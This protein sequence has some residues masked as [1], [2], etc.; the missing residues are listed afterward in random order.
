MNGALVATGTIPNN[1]NDSNQLRIGTS[2]AASS[3][4]V[5]YISNVRFVKGT[6]VYTSAFTPST[7]PLTAITNTQL[8]T[9]QDAIRRDNSANAYAISQSGTVTQRSFSPFAPKSAYSPEVN[10]GSGYLDG[11]GDYLTVA[12]NAAFDVA[13]GD[14]T[15]EGWF[16]QESSATKQLF[17][18]RADTTTLAP[19]FLSI[20]TA[21][22]MNF[23]GS[24]GTG[25]WDVNMTASGANIARI[26][27]WNHIAITRS[28][29]VYTFFV[30]GASAAT[31]TVAGSLMTNT[32]ALSIGAGSAAGTSPYN[33]YIFNFRFVKGVAVYTGAFTPPTLPL[34]TS[35]AASASA[36]PSTTNVNT[37]FASSACSLLCNFTNAGIFD[38]TGKNNL[39]TVGNAQIDTAVKK[40]G[41][42]SMEFDG[43]G[44]YLLLPANQTD[45]AI[46]TGDFTIEAWI[47]STQNNASNAIIDFRNTLNDTNGF[48]FGLA[49]GAVQIFCQNVINLTG[50]IVS[51]NTWYHVALVR[52]SGTIKIY[53]NGTSVASAANTTNW[54]Q[55]NVTIG[56]ALRGNNIPW[57]GFIDDLR[58]TK[59]VARYTSNFT[60]PTKAFADQ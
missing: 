56:A 9:L 2:P 23:L 27:S 7:T 13:G 16:Y 48:Y 26:A 30:N 54:S 6:A 29:N 58:I 55:A 12:N 32:G 40:F 17:S 39:E 31:T 59:G 18:K 51:I 25:S 5:G 38:N 15:I 21:G 28:G 53:L 24:L 45:L 42:G 3:I 1:L 20:D 49:S 19:F 35:G 60:A 8:L 34:S 47:Y 46:G 22:N 52:S 43:T 41:S 10:G 4:F 57:F 33:G 37:S 44:D 11:T 14:F 50:G 36:Y